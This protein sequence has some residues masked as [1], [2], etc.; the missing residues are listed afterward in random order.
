MWDSIYIPICVVTSTNCL[1]GLSFWL[2]WLEEVCFGWWASWH[3]GAS[4]LTDAHEWITA[5]NWKKNKQ[6]WMDALLRNN[7]ANVFHKFTF[8][9]LSAFTCRHFSHFI[10]ILLLASCHAMQKSCCAVAMGLSYALGMTPNTAFLI[11]NELKTMAILTSSVQSLHFKKRP[12]GFCSTKCCVLLLYLCSFYW[13]PLE[14][15]SHVK[16]QSQCLWCSS[17]IGKWYSCWYACDVRACSYN[18]CHVIL[19]LVERTLTLCV[20]VCVCVW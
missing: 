20:C 13:R 10:N 6:K 8:W 14:A 1:V 4:C 2:L 3:D 5:W 7:I 18:H 12:T 17:P 11:G 19:H 16:W 15:S 9:S